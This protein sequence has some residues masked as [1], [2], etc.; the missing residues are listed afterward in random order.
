MDAQNLT[1]TS[2]E[3]LQKHFS[4]DKQVWKESYDELLKKMKSFGG[5]VSVDPSGSFIR[6]LRKDKTF[7][8]V[9]VSSEQ[10]DIGIQIKDVSAAGRF[11]LSGTWN[12]FVTH[13]VQI[14]DTEQIDEELASWLHQSYER[15]K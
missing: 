4:G 2:N 8:I 1:G 5:D 14:T 13:R 15:I 10:L 12:E 3:T 9:E 7:A 11:K 6:I